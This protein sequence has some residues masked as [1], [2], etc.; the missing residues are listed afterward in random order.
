MSLAL[1]MNVQ[2]WLPGGSGRM[3]GRS[4][5]LPC[6][7]GKYGNPG[8]NLLLQRDILSIF[9]KEKNK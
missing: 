5:T 1:N 6:Y 9:S 7:L 3:I 4:S 8:V 2:V